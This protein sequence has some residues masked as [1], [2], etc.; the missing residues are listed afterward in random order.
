MP[1]GWESASFEM[2]TRP[3]KVERDISRKDLMLPS[4][5]GLKLFAECL[6]CGVLVGVGFLFGPLTIVGFA[7]DGH[8]PWI[9]PTIGVV[10]LCAGL[11][12]FVY[13]RHDAKDFI[14]SVDEG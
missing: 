8:A 9:W 14:A 10:S 7:L 5:F 6:G 11:S 3:D 4:G 1:H 2:N 13:V 12:M